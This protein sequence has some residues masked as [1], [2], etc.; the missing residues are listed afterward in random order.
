MSKEEFNPNSMD[1][2]LS[3][4]LAKQEEILTRLCEYN[5]RITSVEQ[6]VWMALGIAT[7]LP[8]LLSVAFYVFKK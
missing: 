4:I 2:K 5:T 6:K 1:A 3:G 8:V 7:S